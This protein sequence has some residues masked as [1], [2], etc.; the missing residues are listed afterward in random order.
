V[1][2]R[3]IV[4]S[5]K[6]LVGVRGSNTPVNTGP[7]PPALPFL[8]RFRT[9]QTERDSVRLPALPDPIGWLGG[10]SARPRLRVHE[11]IAFRSEVSSEVSA[12]N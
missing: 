9:E 7:R 1:A 6:A 10:V 4:P 8:A 2:C 12:A 11:V 3:A 5:P